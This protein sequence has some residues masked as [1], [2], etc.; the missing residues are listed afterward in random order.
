MPKFA[1]ALL[2]LGILEAQQGHRLAALS[3]FQRAIDSGR[4]NA[5]GHAEVNYRI[6][7]IY[8]ALG[9]RKKAV[10]HF[11]RAAQL[12]PAADW[13]TQSQAYLDLLR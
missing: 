6:G 9:R 8:V 11:K 12:A 1:P 2:N 5:S 7:E 13:G 10:D 3:A 4:L